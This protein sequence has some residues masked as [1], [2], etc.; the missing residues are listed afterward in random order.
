MVFSRCCELH[1]NGLKESMSKLNDIEKEYTS[2]TEKQ[3]E[4]PSSEALG[5]QIL[6]ENETIKKR[7]DNVRILKIGHT[8]LIRKFINSLKM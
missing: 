7:I 3:N 2:T 8:E 1:L 6:L 5:L 4:N